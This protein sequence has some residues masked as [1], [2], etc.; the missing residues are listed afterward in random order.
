MRGEEESGSVC[1]L[2]SAWFCHWFELFELT[3][4][5]D[6]PKTLLNVV[7]LFLLE[8]LVAFQRVDLVRLFQVAISSPPLQSRKP[9][10]FVQTITIPSPKLSVKTPGGKGASVSAS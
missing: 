9:R 10:T 4:E 5:S 2:L 7:D 8:V 1:G 6:S 3:F